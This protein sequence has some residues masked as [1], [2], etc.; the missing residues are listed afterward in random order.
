M[1]RQSCIVSA[2]LSPCDC[3]HLLWPSY[4]NCVVIKMSRFTNEEYADVLFTYGKANGHGSLARRIVVYGEL[5]TSN[6]L[7]L[8]LI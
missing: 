6:A 7:R 4:L 3:V 5:E 8:K 2:P 1:I